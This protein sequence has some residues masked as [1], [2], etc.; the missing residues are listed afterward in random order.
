MLGIYS[1]TLKERIELFSIPEPNTGCWIWLKSINPGG[2]GEISYKRKIIRAHRASAFAFGLLK[3]LNNGRKNL[4][5]HRCDN[6]ACVNP[7]HLFIG[8]YLD[9]NRDMAIKKRSSHGSKHHCSKKTEL[10]VFEIKKDFAEG[11]RCVDVV[12]KHKI[13]FTNAYYIKIGKLWKHV[14]T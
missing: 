13:S 10:Q 11:M 2:Y 7:G 14:N 12:K 8:T 3:N 9:N 5:C 1:K 4:V 6:R